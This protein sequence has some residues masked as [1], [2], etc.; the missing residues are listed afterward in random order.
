MQVCR[1]AFRLIYRS[2]NFTSGL[3]L[4]CDVTL[5][6]FVNGKVN[7]MNLRYWSQENPHFD[8]SIQAARLPI[9]MVWRD[10]W[11]TDV[12]HYNVTWKWFNVT[13]NQFV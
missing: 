6:F 12:P 1:I 9:L 7:R 10:L 4:F 8:G 2:V 13:A 11:Q 5:F 3:L